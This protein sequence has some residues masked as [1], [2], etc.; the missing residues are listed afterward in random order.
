VSL[1]CPR[2]TPAADAP[3]HIEEA[4]IAHTHKVDPRMVSDHH[5]QG[6][7]VVKAYISRIKAL[8]RHLPLRW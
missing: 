8:Q 1:V 6:Y 2:R 7:F 5:G 3:F 4:T